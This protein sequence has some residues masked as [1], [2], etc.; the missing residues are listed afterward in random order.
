VLSAKLALVDLSMMVRS[1]AAAET[2]LRP[3]VMEVE[4]RHAAER[5]ARSGAL[6]QA[7]HAAVP[8]EQRSLLE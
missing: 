5:L 4:R 2:E 1:L 6:V 3:L 8:P 7:P